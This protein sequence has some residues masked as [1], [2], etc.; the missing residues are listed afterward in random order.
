MSEITDGD[1]L[2]PHTRLP[3]S[4]AHGIGVRFSCLSGTYDREKNI[5][6]PWGWFTG[7]PLNSPSRGAP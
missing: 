7:N 6:D 4:H 5:H 3:E 1:Y 2:L